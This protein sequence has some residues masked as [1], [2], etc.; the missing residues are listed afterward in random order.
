MRTY[1]TP[2]VYREDVFPA[3]AAEL[4]TGVPAFLGFARDKP[5]FNIKPAFQSELDNEIISADLWQEFRDRKIALS[6]DVTLSIE[7]KGS[8]WLI[9]DKG[10]RQ[11]YQVRKEKGLTVYTKIAFNDPQRLTLWPQFE[12]R[13]AAPR[14]G[15][16]LA[17][18][19][20]GFFANGGDL[21]YVVRLDDT[22]SPREALRDALAALAPLD[23]IDLVCAPDVVMDREHVPALQQEVLDHCEKAGDRFAILDSLLGAGV[24]EVLEH[25]RELRGNNGAL[26]Y[27]WIQVLDGPAATGGFVPPCGHVA[28]VYARSDRRAGVHKAPANEILESVLDLEVNLSAAQQGELN[29]VGVNCLRAF[30]GRGIRVWGARTLS[31]DPAWSYVNVRR[32]FLTAA[33]WIERNMADVVLEPHNPNLWERIK[34]ELNVYFDR[35]FRQGALKGSTPQEAFYVKCDETINPPE[36]R[37]AGLVITEIGLA[38]ALPNEFIVVHIIHGA[39][40]ITI[41]GPT[42]PE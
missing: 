1:P 11:T 40:G 13:F 2:G 25:R 30:P 4:R 15:G 14:S 16:Y 34:R 28:G 32:L 41:T 35:L 29:P 37:D 26:Y 3:P 23:T 39:S 18:A 42:R 9:T 10:H 21:C 5:L 22:V 24:D 36:V 8:A 7:E 33:R 12:R 27:P 17:H 38:P 6:R 20:R 19:V 31:D